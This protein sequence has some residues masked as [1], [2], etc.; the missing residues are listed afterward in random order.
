MGERVDDID[1]II[2]GLPPKGRAVMPP[3]ETEFKFKLHDTGTIITFRWSDLDEY[4]RKRVQKL[5]GMEVV[6]GRL[7]LRR[8]T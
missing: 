3:T 8:K 2:R 4:E 6:D 1:I 5:Y 7:G